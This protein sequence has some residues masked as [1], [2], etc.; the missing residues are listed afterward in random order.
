[1]NTKMLGII[2]NMAKLYCPHCGKKI[3]LFKSNKQRQ[4]QAEYGIELLGEF[5]FEPSLLQSMDNSI[6]FMTQHNETI[7]AKVFKNI[8]KKLKEE[9]K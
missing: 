9:L 7:A 3:D 2:E 4:L 5:P 1:M 6:A 8:V